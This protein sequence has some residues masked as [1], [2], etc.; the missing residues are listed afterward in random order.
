MTTNNDI[1]LSGFNT[2]TGKIVNVPSDI[3]ATQNQLN[4]LSSTIPTGSSEVV[5]VGGGEYDNLGPGTYIVDDPEADSI[6][7]GLGT[8]LRSGGA[9]KVAVVMNNQYLSIVNNTGVLM[10]YAIST[11][12]PTT[13]NSNSG[14]ISNG[15]ELISYPNAVCTYA[16]IDFSVSVDPYGDLTLAGTVTLTVDSVTDNQVTA[17]DPL[18]V[19]SPFVNIDLGNGN[20][21]FSIDNTSLGEDTYIALLGAPSQDT[22]VSISVYVGTNNLYLTNNLGAPVRYSIDINGVFYIGSNYGGVLPGF[23]LTGIASISFSTTNLYG[24]DG[25]ITA[26]LINMDVVQSNNTPIVPADPHVPTPLTYVGGEVPISAANNGTY[27]NISNP[28]GDLIIAFKNSL[29]ETQFETCFAAYIDTNNLTYNIRNDTSV[30]I[31]IVSYG[32]I[33]PIY[34]TVPVNGLIPI[35]M[36]PSTIIMDI[37]P[38]GIG[39]EIFQ[40]TQVGPAPVVTY[41]GSNNDNT[42]F[43]ASGTAI[44]PATNIFI[45]G[46]SSFPSLIPLYNTTNPQYSLILYTS[47]NGVPTYINNGPIPIVL[48][49]YGSLITL[50]PGDSQGGS[51]NLVT[52]ISITTIVQGGVTQVSVVENGLA[53]IDLSASP[54]INPSLDQVFNRDLGI[55]SPPIYDFVFPVDASIT[56]DVDDVTIVIPPLTNTDTIVSNIYSQSGDNILLLNNTG[57]TL[58]FLWSNPYGGMDTIVVPNGTLYTVPTSSQFTFILPTASTIVGGN[59]NVVSYSNM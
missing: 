25:S 52:S 47:G 4:Q 8:G 10:N 32:G 6:I 29:A 3:F 22:Q 41:I 5:V 44:L 28:G 42:F 15:D 45:N 51:N 43:P 34:V 33:I 59:A 37:V 23:P 17:Q 35:T 24:N 55:Y 38:G 20:T 30:P 26:V 54:G 46:T 9:L 13:I 2:M 40:M 49:I 57:I 50:Q 12:Y 16:L 53:T 36:Q 7:I 1:Y 19:N 39:L 27:L 21:L 18:Q 56:T 31:T 48:S 14:L 58:T 11:L